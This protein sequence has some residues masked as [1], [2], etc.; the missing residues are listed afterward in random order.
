MRLVS[1]GSDQHSLHVP[2]CKID[3]KQLEL[4]VHLVQV[5]HLRQTFLSNIYFP[6]E[7]WFDSK[8]SASIVF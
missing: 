2:G 1:A 7:C 5:V 4:V 8:G 3:L 6:A